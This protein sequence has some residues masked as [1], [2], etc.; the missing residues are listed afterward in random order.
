MYPETSSCHKT[1]ST[2][3]DI[4]PD[5]DSGFPRTPCTH[6]GLAH[7]LTTRTSLLVPV[8]EMYSLL[9]DTYIKDSKQKHYLFHAVDNID[10]VKKKAAWAVKWIDSDE[11]FAERVIGFACV[12]G[13][14]FSGRLVTVAK[15]TV[16]LIVA[17]YIITE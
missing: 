13:I 6:L 2:V 10:C 11:C 9:I 14:F 7:A 16:L 12:E 5:F 1:N 17:A 8:T 3:N 4:S 15:P